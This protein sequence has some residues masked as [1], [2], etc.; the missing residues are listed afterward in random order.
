M[1]MSQELERSRVAE[2]LLLQSTQRMGQVNH[3]LISQQE[4]MDKSAKIMRSQQLI[5]ARQKWLIR[6]LLAVYLL[7]ALY[8]WT[9]RIGGTALSVI[10]L[11]FRV[12]QYS[13]ETVVSALG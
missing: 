8:I 13:I 2:Q 3:R 6:L 11:P 1:A 10:S 12:V 9:I 7:S 5:E 4:S